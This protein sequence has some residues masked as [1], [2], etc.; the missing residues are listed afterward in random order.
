MTVGESPRPGLTAPSASGIRATVRRL[1]C[2]VSTA[3]FTHEGR[4][5]SASADGTLRLWDPRGGDALAV[6]ESGGGPLYDVVLS[7]DGHIATLGETD[8]RVFNCDVCGNFEQVR[9]LARSRAPQPL[10]PD[11]RRRFLPT[12]R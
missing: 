5:L 4:V 11:E 8:T 7:P 3:I 1:S 9:A 6:L 2:E 12:Q 10:T